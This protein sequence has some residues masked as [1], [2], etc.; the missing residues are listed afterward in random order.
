[1]PRVPSGG[2]GGTMEGL[3]RASL[4]ASHTLSLFL[5][6]TPTPSFSLSHTLSLCLSLSLPSAGASGA[7][8]GGG[9]D[10][11]RPPEGFSRCLSHTVSLHLTHT[12][13]LSLTITP[14]PSFSLSHTLSLCLSLSLPSAG[15]PGALG[16]GGWADGRPPEG[17]GDRPV[18]YQHRYRAASLIPYTL[19]L[20]PGVGCR[21]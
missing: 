1:M 2:A 3:Q 4:S 15:A 7:L 16:G 18:P 14:S 5:Y 20:Q 10:H 9:R 12:L 21:M 6:L 8:G 19:P 11:G 17:R 13:S